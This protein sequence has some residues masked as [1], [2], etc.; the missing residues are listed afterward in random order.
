MDDI[1]IMYNYSVLSPE[2]LNFHAEI[3]VRMLSVVV[4]YINFR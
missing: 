2:M 1:A 3:M 4:M